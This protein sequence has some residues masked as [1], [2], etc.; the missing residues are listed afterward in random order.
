MDLARQ[1]G[2]DIVRKQ[3]A[4]CVNLM[5][6]IESIYEWNGEIQSEIEILSIFKTKV[7]LLK[8]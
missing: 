3:L 2:T 1:I 7:N 6:K 4:A 8:N 5:P